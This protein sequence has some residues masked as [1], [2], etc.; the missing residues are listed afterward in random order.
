MLAPTFPS[1]CSFRKKMNMI[2][3]RVYMDLHAV[4]LQQYFMGKHICTSLYLP[5]RILKMGS[6][7]LY[8]GIKNAKGINPL[9][10]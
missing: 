1:M 9:S 10:H 5:E 6:S 7:A 2:P 4:I 8:K 3:I